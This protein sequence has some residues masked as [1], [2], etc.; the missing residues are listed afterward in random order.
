VARGDRQGRKLRIAEDEAATRFWFTAEE[1]ER[2]GR[3]AERVA[4]EAERAAKEAALA[5][6]GELEDV[7]R[8]RDP[9]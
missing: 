6:V 7:L 9:G 1:A 8:R 3:Q 2:A 5:R 4:K